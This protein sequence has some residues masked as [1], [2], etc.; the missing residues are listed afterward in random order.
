M[1]SMCIALF[2]S[3]RVIYIFILNFF[4]ILLFFEQLF[5]QTLSAVQFMHKNPNRCW[6]CRGSQIY[7]GFVMKIKVYTFVVVNYAISSL[8]P[9]LLLFVCCVVFSSI[10]YILNV[11]KIFRPT[12]LQIVVHNTIRRHKYFVRTEI[13]AKHTKQQQLQQHNLN[14]ILAKN[15]TTTIIKTAIVVP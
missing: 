9:V 1:W 14:L 7:F 4:S 3:A 12:M 13:P 15:I 11:K 8:L 5:S 6:L 2:L 10:K